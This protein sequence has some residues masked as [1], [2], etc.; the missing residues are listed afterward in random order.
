MDKPDSPAKI[1]A[2]TLENVK[3]F[4]IHGDDV[5]E[6]MAIGLCCIDRQ[7]QT[8][9]FSGFNI[10]LYRFQAQSQLFIKP[11]PLTLRVILTNFHSHEHLFNLSTKS[12]FFMTTD[13]FYN[14]FGNKDKA[15]IPPKTILRISLK[16]QKPSTFP[17]LNTINRSI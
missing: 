10:G 7:N 12:T 14:Q 3:S 2:K 15:K 11:T 1:L 6:S 13:G 9:S 16:T 8:L 17:T 5:S 4:F